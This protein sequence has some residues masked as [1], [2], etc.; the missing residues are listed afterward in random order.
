MILWS[1]VAEP[2]PQPARR[3]P[4]SLELGASVWSARVAVER[5]VI[6]VWRR[7][8]LI[9]S[10]PDR[11]TTALELVGGQR[12]HR[13]VVAGLDRLRIGDPG[14]ERAARGRQQCRRRC[15][16]PAGDMG[17]VG[18]EPAAGLRCRGR[19]GTRRRPAGLQHLPPV[20]ALLGPRA[21]RPAC[22]CARAR[23]R[24]AR[25]AR[26]SPAAPCAHAAGRRTRR[27]GRGRRRARRR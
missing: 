6:A 25:A 7:R 8:A 19:C 17:E 12:H 3:R 1:T 18:P 11:P 2:A 22:S 16:L 21:A 27:I 9:A 24:T 15:V 20:P 14:R 23:P 26:R 4:R 5:C 10:S 13:H